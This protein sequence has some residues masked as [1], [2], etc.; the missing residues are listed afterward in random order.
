MS[1]EVPVSVRRALALRLAPEAAFAL[2]ADVP[3]WAALFP[4]VDRVEAFA[5]AG[6]DAFLWT[7]APLGP[8]GA[9]VRTVY[10]CRYQSDAAALAV[11]W[12]PVE[13][14]GNARFEG[15]IALAPG[16]DGGTVGELRLAAT[17]SVPAPAF[18]RPLVVAA[19]TFEFG[20]MVDTFAARLAALDG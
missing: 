15:A 13:G 3:A 2:L 7:M 11:A 10:A 20:R 8:P 17:L 12:T 16:P 19:V 4:H 6:P 9:A 14:V 1:L 18:A 5:P